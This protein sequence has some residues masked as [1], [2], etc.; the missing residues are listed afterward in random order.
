MDEILINQDVAAQKKAWREMQTIINE[1]SWLVWL[2]A[3]EIKI[4][5]S[6]RFGNV[7]PSILPHRILWNI[8]RLFVKSRE[9]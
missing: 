2:P 4:P 9:S 6:N 3:L 5:V 7:Q 1:Q 8:E